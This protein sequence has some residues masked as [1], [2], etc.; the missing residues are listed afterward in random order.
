[1]A[2]NVEIKAR[3]ADPEALRKRI[4]EIADG[5]PILLRQDDTFFLSPNGRLKLRRT[6]EGAEL[7]YYERE[8]STA[9]TESQ[10]LTMPIDDPATAEAML[11]VA[12]GVRGTVG[13]LRRLYRVGD[14]RI[15]LDEVEGLGSFVELEVVLGASQSVLDGEAYATE[16]MNKM[17]LDE[18]DLVAEAYVDLLEA[19]P[20]DREE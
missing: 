9:P 3:V 1:M 13:K 6:G 16:L 17:D 11:S 2:H 15:H 5:G 18:A 7:I 8:D 4:E 10:Y 14:T 20:E 12:L 19:P